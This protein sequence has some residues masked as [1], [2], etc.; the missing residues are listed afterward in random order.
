M[1]VIGIEMRLCNYSLTSLKH[2]SSIRRSWLTHASRGQTKSNKIK[3]HQFYIKWQMLN[4]EQMISDAKLFVAT[5]DN[6]LFYKHENQK[7]K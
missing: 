1:Y 3:D 4:R 6:S 2:D 7:C 5:D